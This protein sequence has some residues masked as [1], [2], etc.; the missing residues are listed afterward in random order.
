MV[1]R[2]PGNNQ[3]LA[4]DLEAYKLDNSVPDDSFVDDNQ[5][6]KL[7]SLV[8]QAVRMAV[9]VLDIAVNRYFVLEVVL[10][11]ASIGVASLALKIRI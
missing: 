1:V 11:L 9:V 4:V 5:H 7:D 2:S 6:V 8:H 3:L 10:A